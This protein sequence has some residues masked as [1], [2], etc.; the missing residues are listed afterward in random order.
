MNTKNL[1]KK[2]TSYEKI[3][4]ITHTDLDGIGPSIVLDAF[5][6]PHDVSYVETRKIDDAVIEKIE[7]LNDH[8]LVIITD[9][10]VNAETALQIEA[11]NKEPN[12]RQIVILD[13]HA[14]AVYLNEYDWAA[15]VPEKNGIKMS[16]T[17]LMYKQLLEAD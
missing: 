16:A 6:I 7:E 11:V 9:L 14:S 17:T 4:L 2:L 1:P 3:H 10:S 8:E 5:G 13:H 12:G 15:V